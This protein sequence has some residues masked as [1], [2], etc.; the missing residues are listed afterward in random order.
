MKC[1]SE[2]PA[3]S[4]VAPGRYCVADPSG[5]FASLVSQIDFKGVRHTSEK[6]AHELE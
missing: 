1:G 3:R 5:E 2:G 4:V 6:R